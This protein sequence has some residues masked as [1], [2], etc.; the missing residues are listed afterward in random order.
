LY[1]KLNSHITK[2][3]KINKWNPS[4]HFKTLLI[5]VFRSGKFNIR[6]LNFNGSSSQFIFNRVFNRV[7]RFVES[8]RVFFL[9][10]FDF[11]SGSISPSRQN[12]ACKLLY[13]ERKTKKQNLSYS[14]LQLVS[15]GKKM[16]LVNLRFLS[17]LRLWCQKNIEFLIKCGVLNYARNLSKCKESN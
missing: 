14:D 5:M 12:Y 17:M 6:V 10:R 1:F 2:L 4:N 9:T 11:S 7:N 16:K 15:F 8:Y 13:Q 3:I